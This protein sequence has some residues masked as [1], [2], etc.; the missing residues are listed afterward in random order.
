MLYLFPVVVIAICA[1]SL[2]VVVGI[3]LFHPLPKDKY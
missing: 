3:I 2:A 1:V